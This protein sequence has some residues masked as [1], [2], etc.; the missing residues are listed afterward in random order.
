M[1]YTHEQQERALSIAFKRCEMDNH[2][3]RFERKTDLV[4]WADRLIG[5]F[6]RKNMPARKS[7]MYCN[8]LDMTFFYDQSGNAMYTYAG[9]ADERDSGELL[10]KAFS[11]AEEIRKEMQIAIKEVEEN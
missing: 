6:Y 5:F 1:K 2:T 11:K 3:V 4:T 9:Q 7:Y 8:T 10:V